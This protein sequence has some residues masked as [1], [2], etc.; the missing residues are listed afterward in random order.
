MINIFSKILKKIKIKYYWRTYELRVEYLRN[1]GAVVGDKTRLMCGIST[2]GS[3]PYL[4]EIGSDCFITHGCRFITHDGGV[5][6]LNSANYFNGKRMDKMGRI[7]IGDNV[8]MGNYAT[9][10]PNVTVGDNVIIG[11]NSIVT[12]DVPSNCI[13]A[14]IPARVIC[15]LQEYYQKNVEKGV[16]Y[17]TASM[18]YFQKKEFLY[19]NVPKI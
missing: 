8:Y 3:E 1:L 17:E 5:K 9:I 13:V 14:G 12:K 6:V 4:I 11:I 10:M 18:S 15:T 16:F 19:K 2:F 7:K